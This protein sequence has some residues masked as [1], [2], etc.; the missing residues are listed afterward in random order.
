MNRDV[1]IPITCIAVFLRLLT[2]RVQQLALGADE[3][4]IMVGA[5]EL[6]AT[7]FQMNELANS[8]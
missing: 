3:Y 4:V 5:V 6:P 7:V 8:S 2:R 1:V